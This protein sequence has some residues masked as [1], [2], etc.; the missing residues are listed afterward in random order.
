MK[1]HLEIKIKKPCGE[2][3]KTFEKVG[4]VGF[5]G[6]CD[7]SV[8]DF[9]CSTDKEIMEYFSTNSGKICARFRT[10][11]LQSYYL[12][13]RKF[14]YRNALLLTASLLAVTT[15]SKSP[16]FR[17]KV[18]TFTE[19]S[20][21]K[22]NE[23]MLTG[24]NRNIALDTITISGSVMSESN[25]CYL[26]GVSVYIK[27]INGDVVTDSLGSFEILY[28]GRLGDK[29]TLLFQCVGYQESEIDIIVSSDHFGVGTFI[30]GDEIISGK[31]EIIHFSLPKRLWWKIK[32][33]F[34][35]R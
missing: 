30:L 21:I 23:T 15:I 12:P 18:T 3:W 34:S 8:I 26:P 10:Q 27:G 22:S 1:R 9:T 6:K 28:M 32:F 35:R 2:N 11:Q 7:H 19:H 5:C 14:S 24:M 4:N 31:A 13:L 17:E 33:L 29:I 20:K 25:N 16:I